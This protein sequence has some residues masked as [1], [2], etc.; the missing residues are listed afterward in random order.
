MVMHDPKGGFHIPN[1]K[2]EKSKKALV[3]RAGLHGLLQIFDTTDLGKEFAK[4]LPEDGSNRA[5]GS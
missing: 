2:L 3:S 1:V 4:C 5:Y